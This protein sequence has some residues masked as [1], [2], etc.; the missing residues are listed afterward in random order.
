MLT[1][2]VLYNLCLEG[3][4]NS[5]CSWI[6][7]FFLFWSKVEPLL[8]LTFR[9][10]FPSPLLQQVGQGAGRE[11]EDLL[12][13]FSTRISSTNNNPLDASALCVY[14]LDELDR[15]INSTRDLC[16][17]QDGQV[18]G[19]GEVA[20]IEYEVKSSC[21]NL[22]MVRLKKCFCV[23]AENIWELWAFKTM[24]SSTK[25]SHETLKWLF[26]LVPLTEL[27]AIVFFLVCVLVTAWIPAILYTQGFTSWQII[28]F[29]L[30]VP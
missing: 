17:T 10:F 6:S 12:G 5:K 14:P 16:Y 27:H 9:S 26:L 21:A 7:S 25:Y 29:C 22:P 18:E 20:Y 19:R 13:V 15:H 11:G 24:V 4:K 3:S 28:S 8:T 23:W 2:W 1:T 30:Y